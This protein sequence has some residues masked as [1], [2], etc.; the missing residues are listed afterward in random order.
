MS[1]LFN[2]FKSAMENVVGKGEEAMKSK[3]VGDIIG[4][5][6]DGVII[7]TKFSVGAAAVAAVGIDSL[8]KKGMKKKEVNEEGLDDF[9]EVIKDLLDK[10][11][12]EAFVQKLEEEG[13]LVNLTRIKKALKKLS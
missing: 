11:K 13:D 2:G 6:T 10:G 7:A 12:L 1:K 3:V 8:V 9:E 4:G 5:V